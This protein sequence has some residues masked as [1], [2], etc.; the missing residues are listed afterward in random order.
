[1]PETIGHYT[2][3]QPLG[4][5][6][7]G[8]VFLAEDRRLGRKVALK[9][10]PAA[11]AK[12]RKCRQRFITEA[13]AA[14]ALNHPNV[15]TIHE[16]GETADGRPYLTMEF[17]EGATLDRRVRVRPFTVTEVVEVAIQVADALDAAFARGVVHRDLK[18]GNISISDRGLVKVLDFG[19]AK[20]LDDKAPTSSSDLTH[21]ETQVGQIL[22]TPNYMSPEQ[23]TGRG[24]D[25][26]SDLFSFGIVLYE[27]LTGR[28]PFSGANV[29]ETIHR[30]VNAQ[31][32]AIARFNYDVPPE[33]ER[34][35][36]KLLEKDAARRFQTP[37]DLLVDLRNLRRDLDA[38]NTAPGAGNRTLAQ[39]LGDDPSRRT[40]LDPAQTVTA[41]VVPNGDVLLN[42]APIDDQ[43]IFEGR[44][45]WVSQLYR[46]L[47][48][49]ME[50]LSGERIKLARYPGFTGKHET[51]LELQQHL[52]KVKAMV[53]VVSPSFLKAE[54]CR[55]E[56]SAFYQH[57]LN[58]GGLTVGD[59]SRLFKVVKIP[60]DMHDVPRPVAD[61]FARLA[62]FNFFE[63][64]PVTG[65]VR[66]YDESFGAVAKQRF[67]ERIY[68]LAQELCLVL[69]ASEPSQRAPGAAP[70]T[71]R[72]VFLAE[73]T[74]DLRA[75]RDSLRRE[76]VEMGHRVLPATV[77]PLDHEELQAAVREYL[78]QSQLAIHLVGGRYGLIPEGAQESII[79]LQNRWAGERA[80]AQELR[81]L[82][83]IPPSQQPREQ[84]QEQ[85]IG[86]LRCDPVF[87]VGAEVIEGPL[88]SL[89]QLA[90]QRLQ[91]ATPSMLPARSG[92]AEHPPYV[93][94]LVDRADEA[95]AAG[96]Q[97]WLFEQ[98]IEVSLPDHGAD[99]EEAGRCHRELLCACDAVLVFFGEV[100]R[101][102]VETKLRDLLKAPGFGRNTPFSGKAVYATP[103]GDSQKQ[104]FR[105]HLAD[106]LFAQSPLDTA[107][108]R[109]WVDRIKS[110]HTA[111]P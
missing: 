62:D 99:E 13:R 84:R 73:T 85:F 8:E 88:S 71:G 9:L 74:A 106:V 7:M 12:D 38:A 30:I 31:P 60:V 49:R 56:V 108:L 76:L 24:V 10:V 32:E 54:G 58:Q 100:R 33:L 104:R 98:G 15:C 21:H 86:S 1:M 47:S 55:R 45:G 109:P 82:I 6:G 22:G 5:G 39:T 94:L 95:A 18:P 102:W 87:Q 63:H 107:A 34:I 64:D 93:Y 57:T 75:D 67:F 97:D 36:R 41:E 35:V 29:A 19:L 65:R 37:A 52:S 91:P 77:L 59:R 78:G 66:E 4:A 80:R 103:G 25:P 27:L 96:L 110:A 68:D 101:S 89:K 111:R 61:I 42:F 51:D 16:V 70:S 81:R 105:T 44:Q 53:S 69:K 83:W 48:V 17:L 46:H 20:L 26:R 3:L 28:L 43:P 79:E 90:L 72:T 40:H 23:A 92:A 50:Q 2:I 14:S 11:W